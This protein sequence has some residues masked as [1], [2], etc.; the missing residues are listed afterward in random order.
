MWAGWQPERRLATAAVWCERDSGPIDNR[1]QLTKLDVAGSS[2]VSRSIFSITCMPR[3]I[4]SCLIC[5]NWTA[6]RR[7]GVP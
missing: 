6:L 2:P 3:R 4:S 7:I 1:P 5:L